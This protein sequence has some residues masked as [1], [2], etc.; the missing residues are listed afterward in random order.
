VGDISGHHRTTRLRAC[1]SGQVRGFHWLLNLPEKNR[2]GCGKWKFRT[3]DRH[4]HFDPDKYGWPWFPDTVSWVV[5]TSFAIVAL[6]QVP[7]SCGDF[8]RA[9]EKLGIEMLLLRLLRPLQKK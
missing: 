1:H 7:C 9:G 3:A 2:I 6:D 5:S 4:V 8:G